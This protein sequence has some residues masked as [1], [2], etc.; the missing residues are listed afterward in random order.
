[1]TLLVEHAAKLALA[2][3]VLAI[4]AGCGVLD[5]G[6]EAAR[7]PYA[8]TA[9]S[10]P[11]ESSILVLP[12]ELVADRFAVRRQQLQNGW[13]TELVV[14]ANNTAKPRENVLAIRTR[15][16]GT[17]VQRF[18]RGNAVHPMDVASLDAR[19]HQEFP[20]ASALSAMGQRRNRRGPYNFVTARYDDG[21]RC[22][23][24]WQTVNANTAI[25]P[26][27]GRY[28]MEYRICDRERDATARVL[29]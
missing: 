5:G 8:F 22:V 2:L 18:F 14:L 26:D 15:H 24:A 9:S 3:P 1:M 23:F 6:P 27:L 29:N 13:V 19:L 7:G 4:L 11:P 28:A 21:V 12:N 16:G 17:G 25:V 20:G 10:V